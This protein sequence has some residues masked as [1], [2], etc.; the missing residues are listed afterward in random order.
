MMKDNLGALALPIS[1]LP[2]HYHT[3]SKFIKHKN[4]TKTF[5]SI[6]KID[7]YVFYFLRFQAALS[8]PWCVRTLAGRFLTLHSHARTHVFAL[9]TT[10]DSTMCEMAVSSKFDLAAQLQSV[11][12]G[13]VKLSELLLSTSRLIGPRPQELLAL[14]KLVSD[15]TMLHTRAVSQGKI[16]STRGRPGKVV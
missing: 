8:G 13:S 1:D 11:L 7:V 14:S 16:T 5:E 15:H 4:A 2:L 12:V 3:T 10:V 9:H 6:S